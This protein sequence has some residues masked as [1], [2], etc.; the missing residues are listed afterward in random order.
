MTVLGSTTLNVLSD[1]QIEMLLTKHEAKVIARES[2]KKVVE[3]PMNRKAVSK[4]LNCHINTVDKNWK[5]L[6]HMTKGGT[7][8]WYASEIDAA[9]RKL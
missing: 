6:R 3:Q 4:F 2:K 5:H 9:I 8:Y 1:E 7:P